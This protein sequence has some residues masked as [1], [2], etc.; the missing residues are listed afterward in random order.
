[1]LGTCTP[2]VPD[3]SSIIIVATY[4]CRCMWIT[5]VFRQYTVM[6]SWQVSLLYKTGN[7]LTDIGAIVKSVLIIR[8]V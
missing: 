4:Y 5:I 7:H 6:V 2:I 8:S 1:M 3:S